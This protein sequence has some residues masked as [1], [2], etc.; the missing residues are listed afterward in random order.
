MIKPILIYFIL[1]VTTS[2]TNKPSTDLIGIDVSH[3][4][5]TI[6]WANVK[7]WNGKKINF[8]YIKATEGATYLDKTYKRNIKEAKENGLLVGSYHYFRTTSSVK[9]QFANFIKHVD[10]D[11][12]DLIPM[13]DVEEKTNWNNKQFHE[14]LTEFLLLVEGYYGKKPM[15]YSVNSFYNINL[16]NRYKP[17]HF[18]IGR[19]GKNPPNMRDRSNW[20]IWQFSETGKVKGIPKLVD[21]DILNQKYKLQNILY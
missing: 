19:Y 7:E 10:K 17:Y 6:D 5:G 16:S 11:T 13:I 12:Q 4:Q 15:I 1:L 21:I 18:L 14:N 9:D 2:F 3:H 8:V 20:T